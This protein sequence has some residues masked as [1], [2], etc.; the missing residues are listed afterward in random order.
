[1]F[2]ELGMY[3]PFEDLLL[4]IA[5]DAS[6]T[7]DGDIQIRRYQPIQEEYIKLKETGVLIR[8]DVLGQSQEL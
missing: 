7:P 2:Y 1:M 5:L 3:R 8:S 4:S 6:A